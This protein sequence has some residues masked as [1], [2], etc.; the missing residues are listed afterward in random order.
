MISVTVVV[1]DV[2]GATAEKTLDVQVTG[3]PALVAS[4]VALTA[5]VGE[6]QSVRISDHLSGGSGSYRLVDAVQ[7]AATA[8]GLEVNPNAASGTVEMTVAEPGQYVVTYTAQD[9]STQAEQSAVIRITAV[10]DPQ[11][12]RWHL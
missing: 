12:S 1:E 9:V 3:S 2:H 6:L 10:D 7:T 5:R 8:Q 4:P 11:A